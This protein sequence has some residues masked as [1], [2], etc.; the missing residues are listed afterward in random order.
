MERHS[1]HAASWQGA[2]GVESFV[3]YIYIVWEGMP[4]GNE[5]YKHTPPFRYRKSSSEGPCA[6]TVVKNFL[7][8]ERG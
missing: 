4:D 5:D 3:T 7:L 6:G 8:E 2:V 1:V